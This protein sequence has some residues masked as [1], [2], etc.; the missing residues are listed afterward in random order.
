VDI[1]S[2]SLKARELEEKNLQ[3]LFALADDIGKQRYHRLTAQDFEEYRRF[4]HWRYING[5]YNCGTTQESKDWARANSG[6]YC[7]ICG[8]RFSKCGGRTIDH[9]LPR[10]QYPWLSMNFDNLWVICKP[11]NDEKGEMHWFE[12]EHYLLV[13]HPDFLSIVQGFRPIQ[14]LRSLRQK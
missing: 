12:Y 5:S 7:P 11:C 4:D 9:K 2:K 3:E 14:L 13:H 10:S 8:E 6:P 1:P